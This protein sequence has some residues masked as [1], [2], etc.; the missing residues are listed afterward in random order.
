MQIIG[1]A[2]DDELGDLR[3][4]VHLYLVTEVW[5]KELH[6]LSWGGGWGG[7]TRSGMTKWLHVPC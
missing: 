1:K 5:G 7:T 3:L 4:E 2:L 6:L